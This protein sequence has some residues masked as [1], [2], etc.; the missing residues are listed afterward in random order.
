MKTIIGCVLILIVAAVDLS[1]AVSF[2]W[3]RYLKELI[4]FNLIAIK[5]ITEEQME[6]AFSV[7][8]SVCQ[9]KSKASDGMYTIIRVKW[10]ISNTH[11]HTR[12]LPPRSNRRH[13][14]GQV[15][16]P[17]TEGKCFTPSTQ[18]PIKVLCCAN[19]VVNSFEIECQIL[20]IHFAHRQTL[21]KNVIV[22]SAFEAL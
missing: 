8:R 21:Y 14:H 3:L 10:P 4:D 13:S 5:G 1:S 2:Y 7:V 6:K 18:L 19:C 9:P 15:A 12:C 17:G 22:H 16:R 11:V 20:C